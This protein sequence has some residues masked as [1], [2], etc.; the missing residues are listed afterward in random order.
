MPFDHFDWIAGIYA[1]AGEFAEAGRVAGLLDLRKNDTLLDVGGGTGRVARC[2]SARVSRVFIAD[3]SRKMVEYAGKAGLVAA[4]SGAEA[5][6]FP[7]ESFEKIIMV[8]AFH[9]VHRQDVSL[10]EMW[11]VL[12]PGGKLLIIEPDIHFF[13][14]KGIALVEKVLLMRSHIIPYETICTM[15][16]ELGAQVQVTRTNKTAMVLAQKSGQM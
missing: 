3:P 14:V 12:R 15:L 13:V 16:Q 9:H 4:C 6:P 2:L 11:R 10:A 8:D 5:L 7:P 1:R